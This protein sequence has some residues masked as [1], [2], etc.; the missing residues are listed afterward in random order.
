MLCYGGVNASM[1]NAAE[2][3]N[4]GHSTAATTVLDHAEVCIYALRQAWALQKR[5]LVY[6]LY[7]RHS[8]L[9]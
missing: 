5:P 6:R 7:H 4:H 8:D 9:P 2:D 3:C 1:H